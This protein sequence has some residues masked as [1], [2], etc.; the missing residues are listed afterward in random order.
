VIDG[1]DYDQPFVVLREATYEEWLEEETQY[2]V[3]TRGGA[4]L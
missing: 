3:V 2:S 4:V 1:L